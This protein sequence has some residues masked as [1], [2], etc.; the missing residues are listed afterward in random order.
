MP[1]LGYNYFPADIGV[2]VVYDV[3]SIVYNDF[4]DSV[5]TYNYQIKEIVESAFI[6]GEGRETRRL[7]RYIRLTDTLP[8]SIN[9][10]WFANRTASRAEK[11]EENVR[12]IKLI[13]PVKNGA[14]WNG[15]A[16]NTLGNRDYQ[17]VETNVSMAVGGILFDSVLTV[18][19]RDEDLGIVKDYFLEKYAKNA[20]MVYKVAIHL[21]QD[22]VDPSWKDPQKGYDL[23]M[24]VKSYGK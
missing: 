16:A 5:E 7:E 20:G 10:V 1:D 13:F 17:Y 11:V 23:K 15:N 21:E 9:D 12:F 6:D 3:D 4:T 18:L 8:W 19:Q 22:V 14:L 2:W 24:T